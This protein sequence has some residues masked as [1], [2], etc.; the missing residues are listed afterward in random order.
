MSINTT[1]KSL[2]E[3]DILTIKSTTF[4]N[5][6]FDYLVVG[7]G[8]F[9]AVF[10]YQMQQIGKSCLVIDKRSTIAGNLYTEEKDNIHVH[11]YGA[12]IFHTNNKIVWNFI[13]KFAEF[14]NFVNSPIANYNSELYNLPF[15]MN[16]FYQMW[17]TITPASAKEKI[18]SQVE[19][20]KI[21]QPK[22]LE[23]KAISLVGTD[24]YE[25][26]IKGYTKKQWG[27]ECHDLPSSIIERVPLRFTY[28]NN[29]FNAQFQ[30]IPK[31]GYTKIIEKMLSFSQVLLDTDYK[32]FIKQNPK[33]A[34]KI[35]Y[36]GGVDELLNYELGELEYRSL[37]F[38]EKIFENNT[39]QGVAVM[40][41]TDE[42]TPYTR[43]IEHKFFD[44][45]NQENTILSYEYPTKWEKGLESYYPINNEKNTKLY[46]YYKKLLEQ[47]HPNIILGGRLGLYR[48]FDMD[49]IIELALE[50]AKKES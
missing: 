46:E 5:K 44:F 32:D 9:G 23:E 14:N 16:T 45:Q 34:D 7:A 12:H 47:T 30:G 25:K 13:Q 48:Y 18:N 24:I 40:N 33:I 38:E 2:L 41:F 35:I 21:T 22:N 26:L 20:A 1:N 17:G 49:K 50:L 28:D 29:Y 31:G 36:T 42:D 15:N 39:F 37:T 8:L 4:K 3:Q 6:K 10:A 19:L 11:K 43:I 27:K